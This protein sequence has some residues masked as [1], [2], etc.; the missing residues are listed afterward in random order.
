MGTVGDE[1]GVYVARVR[2]ARFWRT[3][4]VWMLVAAIVA[5]PSLL[6]AWMI[7]SIR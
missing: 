4:R 7:W 2:S 1:R 5:I 6:M 3:A